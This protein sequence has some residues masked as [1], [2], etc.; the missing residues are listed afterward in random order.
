MKDG[1]LAPDGPSYRALL[2]SS[3]SNLTMDAVHYIKKYARSGLPVILS[4]GDPGCY[5]SRHGSDCPAIQKAIASL[6]RAK[7]VYRVDAGGAA[8]KLRSLGIHPRVGVRANGTWYPTWRD[9]TRNHAEYAFIFSDGN[10]ATGEVDIATKKRPYFFDPWTGNSKPVFEYK[11]ENDRTVV[12]LRL[13]GNQTVVIGFLDESDAPSLHATETPSIVQGYEYGHNNVSLHVSAGSPDK[14]LGLSTGKV[15]HNLTT[16]DISPTIQLSNWTLTAEHW[17]APQ[18]MSDA[19]VIAAKH[20][21]THQLH[22]PVSWTEIPALANV[23][24]IGYYSTSL[25]WPPP[26]HADGAYIILPKILH[27]CRLYINSHQVPAFDYSAPKADITEYLK[28]GQNE[29]LAVVPTVMWNYI[30]GIFGEIRNAGSKPTLASSGGDLPGLVDNGLIGA[31]EVVP[32]VRVDV[33]GL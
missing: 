31:V 18:N 22:S 23:S 26:A 33:D 4:G 11:Q 7:N 12:P 9:D 27:A 29:I 25:A 15:V 8:T 16:S 28:P 3:T 20:N 19:S 24:G 13:A 14:P 30:R 2:V 32:F 1:M 5:Q 6:K 10:A 21:T 17:N